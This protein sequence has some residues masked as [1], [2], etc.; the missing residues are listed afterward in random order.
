MTAAAKARAYTPSTFPSNHVLTKGLVA[1][2]SLGLLSG[3]VA[4]AN[5]P[6]VVCYPAVN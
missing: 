2:S 1:E 5:D 4:L 6:E 3:S